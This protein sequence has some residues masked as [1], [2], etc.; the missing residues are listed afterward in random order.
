MEN[1]LGKDDNVE[2][3]RMTTRFNYDYLFDTN[4]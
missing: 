1:V 2:K 4:R 3:M